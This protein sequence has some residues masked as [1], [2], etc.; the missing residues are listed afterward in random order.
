MLLLTLRQVGVIGSP[1]QPLD[2]TAVTPIQSSPVSATAGKA[3]VPPSAPAASA[4]EPLNLLDTDAGAQ[5]L[6]TNSVLLEENWKT[7]FTGNR[8]AAMVG[9][10]EFAVLALRGD[11]AVTFD[12]L[13]IFVDG[14]YAAFGVKELAIYISSTSPEGPFVKAAEITVPNHPI[15]QKPFQEF[16][17][18]PVQARFVKLQVLSSPR[19][20]NLSGFRPALRQQHQRQVLV[21]S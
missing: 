16:H 6:Y 12:T 13:A 2:S 19:R 8:T 9:T 5:L 20:T 14:I 17:F 11:K 3:D 15:M 4:T 21:E 18:A 1:V 7:L 10:N